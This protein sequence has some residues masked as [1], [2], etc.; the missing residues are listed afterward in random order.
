MSAVAGKLSTEVTSLLD[1]A[2]LFRWVQIYSLS[3]ESAAVTK[4]V[5]G[6]LVVDSVGFLVIHET[7]LKFGGSTVRLHALSPCCRHQVIAGSAMA[8]C[9]KCGKIYGTLPLILHVPLAEFMRSKE[10]FREDLLATLVQGDMD[11]LTLA[12][13]EHR[14]DEL[15]A[16]LPRSLP[17]DLSLALHS[18]AL[19]D[20]CAEIASNFAA[21]LTGRNS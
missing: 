16:S 15:D 17:E 20:L 11:A 7:S 19:L 4:K 9:S 10:Q 3:D 8:T 21:T 14:F 13:V 18:G 5:L 12:L 1:G 2:A 6:V